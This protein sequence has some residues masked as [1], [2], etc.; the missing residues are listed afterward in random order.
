MS[1]VVL[2]AVNRG[3]TLLSSRKELIKR[4]LGDGWCVVLATADDDEAKELVRLG[5]FLE[6]VQSIGE[7]FL[8]LETIKPHAGFVM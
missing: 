3:Y 1:K 8:R 5:A 7:A 4:F 2:F 6:P